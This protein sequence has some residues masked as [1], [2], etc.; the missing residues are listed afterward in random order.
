MESPDQVT[1][2]SSFDLL[3]LHQ[4]Q[5]IF[6]TLIQIALLLLASK[7]DCHPRPRKAGGCS[8]RS[9]TLKPKALGAC[10]L[11]ARPLRKYI[12]PTCTTSHHIDIDL[13]V[14]CHAAAKSSCMYIDNL[15]EDIAYINARQL[16][17]RTIIQHI[18]HFFQSPHALHRLTLR[19]LASACK[20]LQCHRLE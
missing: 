14:S 2:S 20:R 17:H 3:F 13:A 18:N 19:G 9:Q 8:E 5:P 11:H 15:H 7:R 1:F 6:L 12:A 4:K 16:P 10:A